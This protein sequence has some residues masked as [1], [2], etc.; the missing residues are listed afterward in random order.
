M[1]KLIITIIYFSS[2]FCPDEIKAISNPLTTANNLYGIHILDTSEIKK[3]A[4]LVNNS[5]GSWGYVTIPIQ[6]IDKNLE[7]WQEFLDNC[8]KYKIIPLI[9]L[10]TLPKG[11]YWIKPNEY[12]LVDFANFWNSLDWPIKNRYIIIFNEPNRADEWGGQVSPSEYGYLLNQASKIFKSKNKNFF[13][14]NAGL[15][16]AAPSDQNH[17]D[18]F[19]FLDQMIE[20]V[21]DVLN[22]IDGW[23]S[24][25]YPNPAFASSPY[26]IGKKTV[27]GFLSEEYY[28]NQKLGITNLPLFITETGWS[29]N[30]LNTKNIIDYY[31]YSRLYLWSKENIVA[32]TPFLLF[33]GTAPFNQFSFLNS[34]GSES[35]LY[36]YYQ[37]INKVKGKPNIE[38][39]NKSLKI[40]DYQIRTIYH[41]NSKEITLQIK[42][43]LLLWNAVFEWLFV[44]EIL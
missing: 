15:D 35:N 39:K 25:S 12:D 22:N 37:K 44:R 1:K 7:K 24:H 3:A 17:L 38:T 2:F 27:S 8:L 29:K 11:S 10:A 31:E 4:E 9:R 14:L 43:Q 40:N 28:L 20:A 36:I 16:A 13:I 32:L 33:A 6:A 19:E 26:L 18:S 42:D 21:P 41:P 30:K 23:N 5:N 34:D